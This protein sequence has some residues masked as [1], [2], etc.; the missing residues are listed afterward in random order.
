MCDSGL[1]LCWT[2][3]W[4]IERAAGAGDI[5]VILLAAKALSIV[6]AK[7]WMWVQGLAR[8]GGWRVLHLLPLP[9]AILH[10]AEQAGL[11]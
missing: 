8:L 5:C 1:A 4:N 6:R 11:G 7:L 3:L 10:A 9:M 2:L